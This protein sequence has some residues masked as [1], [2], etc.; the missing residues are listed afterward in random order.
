ML[1]RLP[2][3]RYGSV[4]KLC[5]L[6]KLPLNLC[7]NRRNFRNALLS[8]LGVIYHC[9]AAGLS[10]SAYPRQL[11]DAAITGRNR[12]MNILLLLMIV[13]ETILGVSATLYVVIGLPVYFVWKLMYRAKT[14]ESLL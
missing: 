11:A 13:L 4:K 6:A 9:R 2:H 5:I 3:R 10:P 14:G 12:T 8:F 1:F 7:Y